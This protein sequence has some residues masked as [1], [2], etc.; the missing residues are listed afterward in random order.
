ME[1]KDGKHGNKR[2]GDWKLRLEKGSDEPEELS[3]RDHT[4]YNRIEEPNE[5]S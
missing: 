5:Q 3:F 2:T 1:N 4:R